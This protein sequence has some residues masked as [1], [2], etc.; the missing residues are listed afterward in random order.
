MHRTVKETLP[1]YCTSVNCPS[2]QL[3]PMTLVKIR[4]SPGPSSSTPYETAF[5]RPPG[6]VKPFRGDLT[7]LGNAP[8]ERQLRVAG[9]F[10]KS[11]AN[12]EKM[13]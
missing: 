3:L 5:T 10:T 7:Q 12:S 11:T 8:L 6:I 4:N 9:L 13:T 2:V 1:K